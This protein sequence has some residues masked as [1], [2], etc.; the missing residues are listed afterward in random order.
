L[1][2]PEGERLGSTKGRKKNKGT[3]GGNC[4]Q[5]ARTLQ[6]SPTLNWANSLTKK[7]G[8]WAHWDGEEVMKL[9]EGANQNPYLFLTRLNVLGKKGGGV[10]KQGGGGQL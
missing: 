1:L 7:K 6:E 8:P 9:G 10:E 4:R 3:I 5:D 2:E